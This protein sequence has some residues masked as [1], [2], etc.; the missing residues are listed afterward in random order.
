[1]SYVVTAAHPITLDTGRMV[2]PG[3]E[4]RQLKETDPHNAALLESG[5]LTKRA[6]KTTKSTKSKKPPEASPP[7]Q[8]ESK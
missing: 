4:V 1:M 8:E 3:E 7:E 5:Q 6:V 2:G